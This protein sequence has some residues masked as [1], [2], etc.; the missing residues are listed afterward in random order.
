MP[1]NKEAGLKAVTKMGFLDTWWIRHSH[2]LRKV[3]QTEKNA[4][5]LHT[6]N[7][8][9]QKQKQ[10]LQSR[11]WYRQSTD[12]MLQK[13]VNLAV[14]YKGIIHTTCVEEN[15][16]VKTAHVHSTKRKKKEEVEE[17]KKKQK[18]EEEKECQ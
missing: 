8:N 10:T 5:L 14:R 11:F 2:N 13:C 1:A 12:R 3:R 4:V 17:K 15:S 9:S 6:D 18:E 16:F 7:I